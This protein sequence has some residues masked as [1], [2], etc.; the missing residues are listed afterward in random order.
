VHDTIQD[1]SSV[2]NMAHRIAALQLA[3]AQTE[4]QLAAALTRADAQQQRAAA[5]QAQLQ[6]LIICIQLHITYLAAL[7]HPSQGVRQPVF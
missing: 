5:L 6:V 3:Q 4:A 2:A 7:S 1:G